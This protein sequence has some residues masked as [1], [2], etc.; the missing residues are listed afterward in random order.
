[1]VSQAT[2]K[3]MNKSCPG[4]VICCEGPMVYGH[5]HLLITCP[6]LLTR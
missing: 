1:M 3:L 6:S 4:G 2:K 5:V